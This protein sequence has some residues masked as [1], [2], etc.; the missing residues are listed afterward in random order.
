MYILPYRLWTILSTSTG[1]TVTDPLSCPC[2]PAQSLPTATNGLA[3]EWLSPARLAT[4]H[5]PVS[6]APVW[7]SFLLLV[8]PLRLLHLGCGA[9]SAAR[10]VLPRGGR[11]H[12]RR[13][14][15]RHAHFCALPGGGRQ[16][17]CCELATGF[18]RPVALIFASCSP[19]AAYCMNLLE[20]CTRHIT[21]PLFIEFYC[22]PPLLPAS[23]TSLPPDHCPARR[24]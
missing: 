5:W 21:P 7:G 12:A 20:E 22:V 15:R 18:W 8:Y 16:S 6:L 24:A 9:G 13:D 3:M 14:D 1:S 10:R 2:G 4:V 11:Q 19:L 23:G 17:P